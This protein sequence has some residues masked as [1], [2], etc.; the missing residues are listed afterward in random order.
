MTQYRVAVSRYTGAPEWAGGS[1]LSLWSGDTEPTALVEGDLLFDTGAGLAT[2]ATVPS[3]SQPLLSPGETYWLVLRVVDPDTDLYRWYSS[4]M[5]GSAGELY[6]HDTS[7]GWHSLGGVR[8]FEV[9]GTVTAVPEPSGWWLLASA[10]AA[11]LAGL[12]RRER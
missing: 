4:D 5:P 12:R 3:M 8:A 2:I 11:A 6:K 7:G 1:Y 10:S 9:Q